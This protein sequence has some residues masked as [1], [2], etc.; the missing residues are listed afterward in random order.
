VRLLLRPL[1][2][3]LYELQRGD[4]DECGAVGGMR[5]GRR[6]R[7][8][9]R[10]QTSVQLCSPQFPHDLNRARTRSAAVGSRRLAARSMA[11]PSCDVKANVKLFLCLIKHHDLKAQGK[12]EAQVAT[13]LTLALD[14]GEC[15]V[16][17]NPKIER[18]VLTA[19]VDDVFL[20]AGLDVVRKRRICHIGSR[21]TFPGHLA[22]NKVTNSD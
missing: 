5:I 9:R 22:H 15:P 7:S 10:K 11:W 20:S 4:D 18:L 13:F 17:F 3:V 19:Q 21:T 2:G 1:F 16:L 6:N 14:S 8:T 12:R